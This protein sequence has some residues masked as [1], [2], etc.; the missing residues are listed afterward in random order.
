M[1]ATNVALDQKQYTVKVGLAECKV[2]S[3]SEK[4]A[5]RQARIQLGRQMPQMWDIIQGMSDKQ[6]RVNQVG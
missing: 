4:G 1:S 2:S 3:S 6:F 5:V